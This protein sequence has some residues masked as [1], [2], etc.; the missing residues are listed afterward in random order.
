MRLTSSFVTVPFLKFGQCNHLHNVLTIPQDGFKIG[1]EFRSPCGTGAREPAV[2]V[3]FDCTEQSDL[4][5]AVLYFFQIGMLY[6]CVRLIINVTQC[7]IP[8]YTLETLGLSK[9]S[10]CYGLG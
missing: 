5:L 1:D 9:V 6:M 10:G 2:Y 8:M 7:Y 3:S 4:S